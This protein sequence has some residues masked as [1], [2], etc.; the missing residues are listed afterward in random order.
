MPIRDFLERLDPAPARNLIDAA[1]G[2]RY[3]DFI[4]IVLVVRGRDLFPDNWLYIHDPRFQV[5]RIQNFNNWSPEMVPDPETTCLCLEY[6]CFER[7]SLWDSSDEQLLALAHGELA[8]LGLASAD[9]ILDG[10]VLRVPKA[11]PVYDSSYKEALETV[12]SFLAGMRNLQFIGRNGM[13]YYNNQ[14]HSMVTGIL[15]AK[16]IMGANYD[17]WKVNSDPAYLEEGDP[18]LESLV[19][20]DSS[21]PVVPEE[22]PLG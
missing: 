13:H 10:K 8:G 7:D 19:D 14:D 21:Q 9:S 2:F 22:N 1:R 4:V 11:Y 6:F 20:L 16:N 5:G 3:R 15:A 18:L 17:L 12:R